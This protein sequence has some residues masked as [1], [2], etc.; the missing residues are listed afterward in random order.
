[1]RSKIRTADT[2]SKPNRSIE[3]DMNPSVNGSPCEEHHP[4]KER[5]TQL[6][7]SPEMSLN[8][9]SHHTLLKEQVV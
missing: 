4:G 3:P 1:M 7:A 6:V 9:D 2:S 8:G 5:L